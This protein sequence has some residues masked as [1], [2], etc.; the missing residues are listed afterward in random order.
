MSPTVDAAWWPLIAALGVLVLF[1]LVL[2]VAAA[3]RT[4]IVFRSREGGASG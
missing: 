1:P 4:F 2:A 3:V